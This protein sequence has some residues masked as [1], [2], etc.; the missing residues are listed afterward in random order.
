MKNGKTIDAVIVCNE[1]FSLR[2]GQNS[3]APAG[4]E[5][6]LRLYKGQRIYYNDSNKRDE[7][8]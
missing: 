4:T 8:K 6:F 2:L 7:A 1:S 5:D 3:N